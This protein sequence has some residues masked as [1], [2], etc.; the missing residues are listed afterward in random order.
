VTDPFR[1]HNAPQP[2]QPSLG[3]TLTSHLHDTEHPGP[4]PDSTVSLPPVVFPSRPQAISNSTASGERSDDTLANTPPSPLPPP[5]T[6]PGTPADAAPPAMLSPDVGR[7]QLDTTS[8]D[9]ASMAETAVR[10]EKRQRLDTDT[11]DGR[12][13]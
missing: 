7:S 8:T 3:Q 12:P 10:P 4:Y 6:F 5:T 2:N 11:L 9:L 1:N 13:A